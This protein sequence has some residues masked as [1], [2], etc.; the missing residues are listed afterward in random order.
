MY[1][2]IKTNIPVFGNFITL[3]PFKLLTAAYLSFLWKPA[4][5]SR[6]LSRRAT[7]RTSLSWQAVRQHSEQE[8]GIST[9]NWW[10]AA[11]CEP[12]VDNPAGKAII[13]W[14]KILTLLMLANAGGSRP[15][16]QCK[17]KGL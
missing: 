11:G 16:R 12:A 14:Y 1:Q 4:A 3:T 8:S 10:S 5:T 7:R 2:I 9:C 17:T 6:D 13:Q 15:S